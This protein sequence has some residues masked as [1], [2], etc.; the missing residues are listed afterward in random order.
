MQKCL[1]SLCPNAFVVVVLEVEERVSHESSEKLNYLQMVDVFQDLTEAELEEIDSATTVTTYRKGRILYM[2]EDT[3]QVLFIL[4]Q[5]RVQLYR[6]ST[7]GKKLIIGTIEPGSIFGEMALIGQGMHNSFAEALEDCV[8]YVMNRDEV[9]R[10]LT[11]RPKVALRIFEELGRRLRGTEA[12]LEEIGFRGIPARLA[13][14]LLQLADEQGDDCVAGF[15][16]QE[17]G[18]QIG[19]YRET[20][21]HTLNEFRSRGLIEIGRKQIKILDRAGLHRIAET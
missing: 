8:L 6:I 5:G 21:T 19:T 17:L 20:T 9:E 12:R 7:E 10:L 11:T 13:Q 4:K 18:E 2:P 3:S 15:T 1:V 14:L 16:H